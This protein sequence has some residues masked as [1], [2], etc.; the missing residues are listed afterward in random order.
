MKT[1]VGYAR[2]STEEQSNWSISGQVETIT[3]FAKNEHS[4]ILEIFTDEGYSAKTFNRPAWQQLQ[5]FIKK[6]KVDAILVTAYDRYSRNLVEAITTI[7]E[8]EKKL[9]VTIISISQNFGIDRYNPFSDKIRKDFFAFAEFERKMISWRTG[10]GMYNARSQ[11]R[12]LGI[13]PMGYL[14]TR[15]AND[16]PILTVDELKKPVIV[17]LFN[18]FC[19]GDTRQSIIEFAKKSGIG[20]KGNV[21]LERTLKNPVYAGFVC[22]GSWGG[23]A[24]KLVKGIH[25]P[26]I[27]EDLFWTVQHQLEN[28]NR[29]K[30][31][32]LR[33]D[34]PLRGILLC[35]HGHTLTGSFAK[36]RHGGKYL[37]Y[38]CANCRKQNFL[39][40]R[41]HSQLDQ[42]LDSLSIPLEVC[43]ELIKRTRQEFES[44]TATTAT[45]NSILQKKQ[46]QLQQKIESLEEKYLNND[47]NSDTYHRWRSKYE[48]ENHS[49]KS[50]LQTA[51]SDR[52]EF[53]EYFE[54]SLS[55]LTDLKALYNSASVA[56]RQNFLSMIFSGGLI[57]VK[58]GFRT[59]FL[60][61]FFTC[62]PE[63]TDILEIVP[64]QNSGTFPL[65]D[66]KGIR[67]PI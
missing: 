25:E 5:S 7:E 47:I 13:A 57:K 30:S 53:R 22:T 20:L 39:A 34:L 54:S 17:E 60:H 42:L 23:K 62:N 67:T 26:I 36:G 28:C 27:S 11:G 19:N 51:I 65:C 6:N 1:Y 66:P 16:K 24:D 10:S 50:E 29:K 59:P 9:N 12:F 33:D 40:T 8:F 55:R 14:N 37:Y 21:W 52:D 48:S 64:T 32:V 44:Y 46:K 2:I 38:H 43:E 31:S 18:R 56:D 61:S 49:V 58:K 4:V 41:T 35:E 63:L 45:T 3:Q 15:D